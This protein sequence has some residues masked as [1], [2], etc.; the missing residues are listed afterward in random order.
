MIYGKKKY[1]SKKLLSFLNFNAGGKKPDYIL[2]GTIFFILVFGLVMLSSASSVESFRK[3]GSAYHLFKRQLIYGLLPG[4]ILFFFFL[5]FD[6][7]KLQKHLIF[8]LILIFSFLA[9]VFV[10]GIGA[11]YG[12]ATSWINVAGFSLQPTEIVKL[13]LVLFLAGWFSQ[14]SDEMNQDF[15]NGLFPFTVILGLVSLIA[16][17]GLLLLAPYRVARLTTFLHPELDPKGIGYQTNQAFYY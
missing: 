17:V 2:V 1:R 9:I 13:L 16:F 10:P 6:Y 5:N 7:K 3:F 14:R 12:R 4:V 15:W 11:S 8:Y